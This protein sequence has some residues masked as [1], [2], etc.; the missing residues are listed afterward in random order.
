M[1]QIQSEDLTTTQ[2]METSLCSG[3]TMPKNMSKINL[4]VSSSQDS[5]YS[6][7]KGRINLTTFNKSNSYS[8]SMF[9]NSNDTFTKRATLLWS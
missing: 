5:Y 8:E 3:Y 9:D 4:K 1:K 6:K 7:D 2:P